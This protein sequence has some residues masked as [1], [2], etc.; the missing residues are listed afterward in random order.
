MQC[1]WPLQAPILMYTH[2][3]TGTHTYMWLEM[4]KILKKQNQE[5]SGEWMSCRGI[6]RNRSC[7]TN[8]MPGILLSPKHQSLAVLL[9]IKKKK[10]KTMSC[11][12]SKVCH[13][14]NCCC[15]LFT[16]LGCWPRR[17]T[18]LG[19]WCGAESSRALFS[20]C[21]IEP[22]IGGSRVWPQPMPEMPLR[23]FPCGPF[24]R[25]TTF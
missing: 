1:L 18:C 6:W 7:G 8:Y 13:L 9:K 22:V 10:N 16:P 4:I 12:N 20:K 19:T 14:C 25:W 5:E 23:H 24:A 3:H 15:G 2:P 17:N 21:T 11:D